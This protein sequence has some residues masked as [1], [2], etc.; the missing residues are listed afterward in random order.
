MCA[1]TR[2]GVGRLEVVIHKPVVQILFPFLTSFRSS[3]ACPLLPAANSTLTFVRQR[4]K[5][6]FKS[7]LTQ[8]SSL[9]NEL[10]GNRSV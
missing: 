7:D 2:V 3:C 5:V 8:H 6:S 1:C 10:E 4:Q 9:R